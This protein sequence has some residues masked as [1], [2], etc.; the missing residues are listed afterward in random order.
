MLK[1]AGYRRVDLY[2][3]FGLE[4]G[5]LDLVG[6]VLGEAAATGVSYIVRALMQ[7]IGVTVPC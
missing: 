3:L 4:A 1:T 7:N 2:L 6:G 5:L